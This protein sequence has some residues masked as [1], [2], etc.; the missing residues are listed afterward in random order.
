MTSEYT[1]DPLYQ[2]AFIHTVLGLD[3]I[4]IKGREQKLSLDFCT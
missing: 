2:C 1:S 3:M 4:K